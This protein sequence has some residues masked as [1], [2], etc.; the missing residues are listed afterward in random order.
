MTRNGAALSS[1]HDHPLMGASTAPVRHTGCRPLRP[2]EVAYLRT[3]MHPA[4][5]DHR[6][7]VRGFAI[8]VLLSSVFWVSLVIWVWF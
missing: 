7:T 1:I 4:N 6:S 5:D 2:S 3:I 8:G